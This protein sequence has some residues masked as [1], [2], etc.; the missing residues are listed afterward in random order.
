M[1]SNCPSVCAC[2]RP[3]AGMFDWS[4]VDFSF[5]PKWHFPVCLFNPVFPG[6]QNPIN[7]LCLSRKYSGIQH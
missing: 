4:A 2:V 1:F 7:G 3:D 5:W 6:C